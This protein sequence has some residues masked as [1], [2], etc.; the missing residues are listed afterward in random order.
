MLLEISCVLAFYV[1]ESN[2]R[3]TLKH[4]L[5]PQYEE[6]IAVIILL[7]LVLALFITGLVGFQAK[8]TFN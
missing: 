2:G 8:T 4:G 6:S 5:Q 7:S 3:L 1:A